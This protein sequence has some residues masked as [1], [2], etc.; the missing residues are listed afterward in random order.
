MTEALFYDTLRQ[1]LWTAFIIS[2][3]ILTVALITGLVVGLFQALTSIQE[4]T[5]T[6]VPK[7]AAIVGTFWITMN[8]MTETL[9]SLFQGTLIPIIAGG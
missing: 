1:G 4:M 2:I 7:L 9:V 3:P 6:F 5:L 8:Y